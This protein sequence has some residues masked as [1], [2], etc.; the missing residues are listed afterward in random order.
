MTTPPLQV[1]APAARGETHA[2]TESGETPVRQG[3]AAPVRRIVIIGFMGAGKSTVG[4]LLA[5]A[6]GWDFIDLDDEVARREG[7][8]VHQ[9]IRDRGITGFRRAESELGRELLRRR[10]VVISMGGGWPA[11]P[12]HMDMLEDGTMSVWLRVGTET[13]LKRIAASDAVRPLLQVPDPGG[14]AEALLRKRTPHYGRGNIVVDADEGSPG[15]VVRRILEHINPSKDGSTD[16][17]EDEA[18]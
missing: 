1:H 12:G 2:S 18:E 11:E 4:S 9:I 7:M 10:S 8:P 13:A 16:R 17:N 15:D 14:A 5:G 6:V 3:A